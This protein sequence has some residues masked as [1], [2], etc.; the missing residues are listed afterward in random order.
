MLFYNITLQNGWI[1]G[2][3]QF[4][5]A[6]YYK[7]AFG[8]VFLKGFIY[9]GTTAKST[10][11]FQLPL[12]YRPTTRVIEFVLN[13]DIT[14][15]ITISPDGSAFIDADGFTNGYIS[16]ENVSFDTF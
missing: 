5:V 10:V 3:N 2:G 15:R 8:R 1:T 13:D 12:G 4:A 9:S 6:S 7:T 14:R 16:L 11:L